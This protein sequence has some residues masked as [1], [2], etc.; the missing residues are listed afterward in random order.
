MI[1]PRRPPKDP[2]GEIGDR[3]RGRRGSGHDAHHVNRDEPPDAHVDERL[4]EDS[5]RDQPDG[6]QRAPDRKNKDSDEAF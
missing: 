1:E 4:P 2:S 6:A 3:T 5:A